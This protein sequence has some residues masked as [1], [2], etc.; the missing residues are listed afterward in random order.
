MP[1]WFV[2]AACALLQL[3]YPR[4][5][6]KVLRAAPPLTG[7]DGLMRWISDPGIWKEFPRFYFEQGLFS[8]VVIDSN[9]CEVLE[10]HLR[11]NIFR[12]LVLRLV[13]LRRLRIAAMRCCSA[14]RTLPGL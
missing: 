5:A 7:C 10:Q 3:Q 11:W 14:V 13:R 4:V 6:Q 1:A 2:C 9:N 12:L 8:R